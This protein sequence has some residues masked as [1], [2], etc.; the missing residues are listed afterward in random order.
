MRVAQ[1]M[2]RGVRIPGLPKQCFGPRAHVIGRVKVAVRL[3]EDQVVGSIRGSESDLVPMLLLPVPYQDFK[4]K[5]VKTNAARLAGF[6]ALYPQSGSRL[7][8]AFRDR[9]QTSFEIQIGPR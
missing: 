2:E 7:L 5:I 1:R 3:G 8:E 4:G 6:C 9:Y